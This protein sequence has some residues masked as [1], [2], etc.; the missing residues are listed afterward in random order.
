MATTR[1][2]EAHAAGPALFKARADRL[3]IPQDLW[4]DIH[5]HPEAHSCQAPEATG[6]ADMAL[7]PTSDRDIRLMARAAWLTTRCQASMALYQEPAMDLF[8]SDP[9]TG[10]KPNFI[11]VSA[12]IGHTVSGTVARHWPGLGPIERVESIGG[13]EINSNNFRISTPEGLFLAKRYPLGNDREETLRRLTLWNW[14]Q[15]QGAPFPESLA[16]DGQLLKQAEDGQWAVF[17]FV[18]G[19]FF[20]GIH[21]QELASVARAIGGLCSMMDTAPQGL[22]PREHVRTIAPDTFALAQEVSESRPQWPE[23]FLEHAPALDQGW[24]QAALALEEIAAQGERLGGYEP[25]PCH[26]DLHPLNIL[27]QDQRAAAFLDPDSLRLTLPMVPLAYGAYKLIKQRTVMAGQSHDRRKLA[28]SV[29]LFL[30][31]LT[32]QWPQATH[33]LHRFGLYART[34][35]FRRMMVIFRS[36]LKHGNREWNRFLPVHLAGIEETRLMFDSL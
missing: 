2:R 13:N 31:N 10:A 33:E 1:P 19:E 15:A 32:L 30:E 28:R 27:V 4:A 24:D 3:G 11:P 8:T 17:V 20:S 18:H 26:I 36:T 14:L 34:E 35:I 25:R 9:F 7:F 12:G 23:L 6:I 21:D 22:W 29:E 5:R 16:S